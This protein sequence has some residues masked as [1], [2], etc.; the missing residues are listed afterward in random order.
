M[1]CKIYL[2]FWLFQMIFWWRLGDKIL[3]KNH[4][5]SPKVWC[6]FVPVYLFLN[7]KFV[8]ISEC[9]CLSLIVLALES[10]FFVSTRYAS[11]ILKLFYVTIVKR[12]SRL[13]F[14]LWRQIHP[15]FCTPYFETNS[16]TRNRQSGSLN[17][18]NSQS[19]IHWH[20]TDFLL[21]SIC[22]CIYFSVGPN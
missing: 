5:F 9:I 16:I 15:S 7:L 12:S 8:F 2:M 10:F 19:R 14:T 11:Q 13:H 17:S 22:L 1:A 21:H 20:W 3:K 4:L 6:H 18:D